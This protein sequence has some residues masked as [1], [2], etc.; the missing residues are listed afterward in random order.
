M[1]EPR[2]KYKAKNSGKE[3]YD[4][5]LPP[6]AVVERMY[7]IKPRERA[8]FFLRT[9][10]LRRLGLTSFKHLANVD[11][12]QYSSFAKHDVRWDC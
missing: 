1:W 10:H 7:N 5:T 11:G 6:N 12:K 9:L 4:F 2:A 3:I 8:S